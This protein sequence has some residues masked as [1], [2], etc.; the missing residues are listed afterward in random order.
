M[1][2]WSVEREA[3]VKSM[4]LKVRNSLTRRKEILTPSSGGE[5]K[6]FVCGPTV[7][8]YVHLGHARTYLAFDTITRYLK[9]LGYKVHYLMNITDV[10][11]RV[12]QRAEQL[13]RDP[14]DLAREYEEAFLDDMRALGVTEVDIFERASDAIPR[15]IEQVTGLIEK[16]FAYETQTGVYFEV[17]KYPKFGQLSGQSHEELSLRRLELCSSKRN[18]EDFSLWRKY[19]KGLA[20]DSP[21]GRGRPGWHIEDTAVSMATFGDTYDIHG[22]ASELIFPH[23]EAEIAQAESLTGKAP[24]VRYWLHT[25]LLNVGVRKMSKSLGNMVRI[26]DALKEYTAAELRFYFASV[27]YREPMAYSHTGL[28]R[29]RRRLSRLQKNFNSFTKAQVRGGGYEGKT[30]ATLARYESKFKRFMNDDFNTPRALT[31][32]EEFAAALGRM[33]R[34]VDQDSKMNLEDRFRKMA[35]VLGILS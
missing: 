17:E 12:V 19:D 15:M 6:V 4:S 1:V 3:E 9:F 18:P 34:R 32:L 20:W 29:A 11:E 21:W 23:H 2:T 14:V 5:L 10:A 22:G 31:V 8:D 25:G 7:Y 26:R 16:G 33:G 28:K 13:K 27:H 35:N 30:S 24:F